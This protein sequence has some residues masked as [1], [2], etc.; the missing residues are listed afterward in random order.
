MFSPSIS[1]PVG[2]YPPRA[3]STD[4]QLVRRRLGGGESRIP[5]RSAQFAAAVCKF[6]VALPRIGTPNSLAPFPISKPQL[7]KNCKLIFP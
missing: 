2:V 1:C 6:S 4:R 5:I 3:R 7:R